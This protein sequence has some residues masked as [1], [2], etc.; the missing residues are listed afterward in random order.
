MLWALP[1]TDLYSASSR[2]DLKIN[3]QRLS[4]GAWSRGMIFALHEQFGIAVA[5]LLKS[6][7][8]RGFNSR[9]VQSLWVRIPLREAL[10]FGFGSEWWR[11]H[12]ARGPRR[13][14]WETGYLGGVWRQSA[15]DVFQVVS[16]WLA[17]YRVVRSSGVVCLTW[18]LRPGAAQHET[19]DW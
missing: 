8:G 16:F 10:F 15:P 18:C 2:K 13:G 11:G 9:S 17:R 7:N 4:E 19:K 6:V 14:L 3:A 5:L 12:G 1:S